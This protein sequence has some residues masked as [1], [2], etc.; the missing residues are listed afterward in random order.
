MDFGGGDGVRLGSLNSQ[1]GSAVGS[2]YGLLDE[3]VESTY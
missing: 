3:L 2:Q 1:D